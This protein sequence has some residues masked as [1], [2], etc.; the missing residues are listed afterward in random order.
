MNKNAVD[1]EKT[2]EITYSESK[3]IYSSKIEI[4]KENVENFYEFILTNTAKKINELGVG[5]EVEIRKAYSFKHFLEKNQKNTLG[6]LHTEKLFQ[7]KDKFFQLAYTY[8]KKELLLTFKYSST[9]YDNYSLIIQ[10]HK[11]VI[12]NGYGTIGKKVT[13]LCRK[14]GFEIIGVTNS[15]Y[16]DEFG[17]SK[18]MTYDAMYKG[19]PLYLIP[20]A[21][22]TVDALIKA[23]LP[24][25]GTLIE[26]LDN[27]RKNGKKV[28]IVDTSTGGKGEAETRSGCINNQTIYEPYSDVVEARL[29]QGAEDPKFVAEGRAFSTETADFEKLKGVKSIEVVSCNTTGLN[30]VFKAVSDALKKHNIKKVI[31]DTVSLRREMDPGA[32]TTGVGD[33]VQIENS[34]IKLSTKASEFLGK[35]VNIDLAYTSSKTFFIHM[36]TVRGSLSIEE[37]KKLIHETPQENLKFLEIED[38]KLKTSDLYNLLGSKNRHLIAFK[39]VKSELKNEVKVLF[40]YSMNL[41][42]PKDEDLSVFGLKS[43]LSCLKN[44]EKINEIDDIVYVPSGDFSSS[45]GGVSQASTHHTAADFKETLTPEFLEMINGVNTPA[46]Q[47]PT[48]HFH[49]NIATI[50]AAGINADMIRESLQKQNRIALVHFIKG[51]FSS[52]QIYEIINSSISEEVKSASH[53]MVIIAQVMPSILKDEVKIIY[54]VPQESNVVPENVN[55]IHALLG[56]YSKERSAELVNDVAEIRRIKDGIEARLPDLKVKN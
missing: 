37:I 19:Y 17:Q 15:G 46:S 25:K 32:D 14:S 5:Y 50:K 33:H 52:S 54:A 27:M 48:T 44:H 29:F 21:K 26:L 38:K 36:A 11:R 28:I 34:N 35:P 23:G 30:R 40:G 42:C 18:Y 1:F 56:L 41:E 31:I 49:V 43:I 45:K 20:G 2:T 39:V 3:I 10:P 22:T 4:N 6:L 12:I 13:D 47:I 51:R 9:Y 55:A 53:P 8:D 7:G 24:Y 16:M